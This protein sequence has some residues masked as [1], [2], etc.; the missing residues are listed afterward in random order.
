MAERNLLILERSTSGLE[1]TKSQDGSVILE[2]VFTQFGVRNKNNR[3]YEEQEVMPHIKELQEKVKTKKLLGELDH[4]K[5]FDISLSNVSHVIEDLSYDA[6]N[7]Q[8]RGRIR[9]LNTAKGK[10]AKALIEDGIPLHISS[11]AAGTVGDDGRVKIKKWFTYDLVADPGFEN[12]ELSRVNESFG[13]D[14]D[15]NLFIYEINKPINKIQ[16]TKETNMDHTYVTAEDFNKYTEYLKTEIKSLK[17][18]RESAGSGKTE[19]LVKYAESIAEK[20]NGITEY[21]NY[22][23]ESFD[24]GITYSN[25]LAENMNS[26]KNYAGYIA[27]Q[28]DGSIRYSEHVAE[29]A[30]QGIQFSNYLAEKTEQS[31]KFS[32][33]L[34]ESLNKSISYSEYVGEKTEHAIMYAEYLKEGLE[35]GLAY[36]DYIAEQVNGEYAKLVT[37]KKSGLTGSP[38]QAAAKAASYKSTLNESISALINKAETKT[39]TNMAFMNF[40]TENK[41][42]EFT[43]LS[44]EMQG[45]IVGAMNERNVMS[46]VDTNRIWDSCFMVEERKSN[47]IDDMPAK[48]HDKWNGLSEGRKKQLLAEAT[49]YPLTNAYQINNFWSTRDLREKQVHLEKINESISPAA[50]EVQN[51]YAVSAEQRADIVSRMKFNL[52]R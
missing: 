12:A 8:V 10:E 13:F 39:S 37:E 11:R 30:D 27:E 42:R 26:I 7:K 14:N 9:L 33:Y 49:F 4:P 15:E 18:A 44:A 34:G 47:F 51:Q 45:K 40:L 29:K 35:K 5:D 36:S 31:I 43:A 28:L 32:N 41:K 50:P 25:Y 2:G 48:Y 20:V 6:A 24:K 1:T 22:L 52:G 3:I 38:A 16:E 46:T 17:E 21:V 23:A 19:Q